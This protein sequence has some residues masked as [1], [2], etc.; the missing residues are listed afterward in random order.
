M[1]RWLTQENTVSIPEALFRSIE[2]NR[3]R[4][5]IDYFG[6][7]ITYEELGKL[8]RDNATV[9]RRFFYGR[10][11]DGRGSGERVAILMPNLPQFIFAYYGA[12]LSGAI[13]VPINFTSIVKELRSGVPMKNIRITDEIKIQILDSSPRII[14][15][16]DFF[17]PILQQ[18]ENELMDSAL[19]ATSPAD[20]LPQPLKLLYPLKA[21][22]EGKQ[23]HIPFKDRDN[24]YFLRDLLRTNNRN[25]TKDLSFPPIDSVAQLQYTGGTTGTPKGAMLTHKNI[26]VNVLQSREHMGDLIEQ[27]A[28]VLGV[29]PFFHSYGLTAALNA[30]FLAF[31]GTLIVV[32]AFSPKKALSLIQEKRVNLFPGVNRM[33]QVMSEILRTKK[34]DLSS[35]ELC[36]SGAGPIDQETKRTFEEL[37]RSPI[38]EGYGLSEASPI[39]SVTL[40]NENK[41]GSVGRPV[42]GTKVLIVDVEKKNVLPNGREGEI[43]VSGPQ[44]MLG[45]WQNPEA[46][47]EVLRDGWLSTADIGHLD[48]DGYLYITDRLKD[49]YTKNGENVYC[50]PVEKYVLECPAVKR[51]V[52][53]GV[54][55]KSTGENGILFVV[56]KGDSNT[57]EVKEHLNGLPNFIWMPREVITVS[58]ETFDDWEDVL[59]K[60]QRRKVREYYKEIS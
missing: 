33:F 30:A 41:V 18:I 17:W 57:D 35:L 12:L 6:R 10:G 9:F 2:K 4:V 56:L 26:V 48:K 7:K 24:I 27:G 29:L 21:R 16:A 51:C 45:Y 3:D 53:V 31:D 52:V 28:I 39:V 50:R 34:Y 5:A 20:F 8:V 37:S 11:S 47:Q 23:A 60:I 13:V 15:F 43:L 54:P 58:E 36:F 46:T 40:P 44:V 19:I 1:A 55:D 22:L 25:D 38:V 32:P 59:G 14:V 49:M 42:C